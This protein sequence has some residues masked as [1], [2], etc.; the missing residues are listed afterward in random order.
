MYEMCVYRS[1]SASSVMHLVSEISEIWFQ[2]YQ[3]SGDRFQIY[4]RYQ[5]FQTFQIFD[6]RDQMYQIY[7]MIQMNQISP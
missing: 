4:Q 7:Q 2:T 1:T 5:T 6:I 3:R